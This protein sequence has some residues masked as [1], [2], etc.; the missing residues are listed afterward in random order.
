MPE[1]R[2]DKSH[3]STAKATAT[4]GGNGDGAPFVAAVHGQVT[5]V[6]RN[7][8]GELVVSVQGRDEPVVDCRVA[9]SFPWSQ[10]DLFISICD[11]DGKE[12][13]LL[14][15]LDVLPAPARQLVAEE[16]TRTVFNPQIRRI[17]QCKQEFDVTS[18]TAETDR[19]EVTFQIRS[20]DDV[21]VLSASRALF[22]DADGNTYEL[23]DLNALDPV[24][25]R[26]IS[27][28]F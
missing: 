12:V 28:Y 4:P 11:A 5:E 20:R 22:R 13:A 21:R 17:R 2:K 8:K 27:Q 26:H 3:A 16:L 15:S 6:R 1:L 9:R 7:E 23:A 25:R 10:P 14:E 24:S 19:G 18:I